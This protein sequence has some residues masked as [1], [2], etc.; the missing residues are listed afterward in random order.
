MNSKLEYSRFVVGYHG[1][2]IHGIRRVLLG[3]EPLAPSRNDYDW[4]GSG[5]YFWEQGPAR[6]F[7]FAVNESARRPAKVKS[8]DVVGAYIFLG[9]CFDLLDVKFTETLAAF[10]HDFH[11]EL[12]SR[13]QPL[14]QNE[15]P[16]TDGTKLLHKLDRAVIEYTLATLELNQGLQFDTVRGAFTEG[17][18]VYPGAEIFHQTHIQIAVRNPDCIMG[19]FKPKLG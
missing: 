15:R 6:A 7:Q 5:I 14:P 3:E 8:P 1:G 19:Y 13:G 9:R 16:R 10:Y 17:E 12:K 11:A 18:R 2:D 4:L